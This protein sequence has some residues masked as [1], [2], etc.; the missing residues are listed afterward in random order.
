MSV[1]TA[2][3]RFGLIAL[4][5]TFLG[6]AV[7]ARQVQ[8]PAG[9][10]PPAAPLQQSAMAT[11]AA[12]FF[13]SLVRPVL[14]ANCYDC[15]TDGESGGLRLDSLAAI[16]RGGQSGPAIVVGDPD[17][18][19]LIKAI[20]HTA[21]FPKMPSGGPKLRDAEIDAVVRWIREGALWPESNAPAAPMPSAERRLTPEQRAFWSFQPIRRVAPPTVT[22]GAWPKN[23]IDRSC[24]H[25]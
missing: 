5:L 2:G 11:Q 21:G 12:E 24:T 3:R 17:G 19:L 25:G 8:P 20:R 10:T 6:V 18:S 13:E 14:V 4:A 1:R 16:L 23:D 22:N 9:A 15:H 7:A